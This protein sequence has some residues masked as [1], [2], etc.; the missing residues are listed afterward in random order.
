MTDIAHLTAETFESGVAGDTPTLV[1]FWAEWCA[2]CRAVA[3]ILAEIADRARR[4]LQ[5]REAQRRREPRRR[6]SGLGILGIPTLI[7]FVEGRREGARRR[8]ARE[9]TAAQ[10]DRAAPLADREK[11]RR[12]MAVTPPPSLRIGDT[13]S[14]VLD[15]QARLVALGYPISDRRARRV[16]HPDRVGGQGLPDPPRPDAGRRRRR[17]TRGASSSKRGGRSAGARSTCAVRRCAATTSATCSAGSTRSA[18][19]RARRTASSTSRRRM[20]SPSS[21]ATSAS[22]PTAIAGHETFDG[23][24]PAAPAHRPGLEGGAARTHRARARRRP[25]RDA[26]VFLDPGHGGVDTGSVTAGRHPRGVHRLPRRRVGCRRARALG[27][28][29][30][31]L[32]RRA[33]GPGGRPPLRDRE[34]GGRRPRGLVPLACRPD[35]GPT[36]AFWSVER[37]QST[38]GRELAEAIGEALR[39]RLGGVQVLGRNLPFLRQTKMPSVVVDLAA[40]GAEDAARRGSVPRRPRRGRRARASRTYFAAAK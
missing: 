28:V 15:V 1:D 10:G 24:R 8:R 25:R 34:R 17:S 19:T 14:P 20:R 33:A 36:V 30:A 2:P 29:A 35:P 21:S 16:R 11:G 18:S 3:P 26:R 9:G 12:R 22:S 31:V 6:A 37:T 5:R 32:A 4:T 39:P 38:M 27:C 7:L 23:A 13:G 40:P